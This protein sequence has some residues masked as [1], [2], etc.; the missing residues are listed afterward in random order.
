MTQ[1]HAH[2]FLKCCTC[3]DSDT[4]TH[5]PQML[6]DMT[7]IHTCIPMPYPHII[8]NTH[9]YIHTHKIHT[10]IK[11]CICLCVCL[12]NNIYSCNPHAHEQLVTLLS[13]FEHECEPM[14]H[15]ETRDPH[16]LS[17]LTDLHPPTIPNG[18]SNTQHKSTACR[19][20]LPYSWGWTES[21]MF[22]GIISA[23]DPVSVI[24][25]VK[26]LGVIP[27]FGVLMEGEAILN[28]GTSMI[29]Y[30]LCF[31]LLFEQTSPVLMFGRGVQLVIGALLLGGVFFAVSH[32]CLSRIKTP[33]EQ[34]IVTVSSAYLC[35]FVAEATEIG[36]SGV[37]A[38]FMQGFLMA[39]FGRS[40]FC[41]DSQ[42]TLQAFWG[43]L[44]YLSDTLVFILAGAIIVDKAFLS[45]HVGDYLTA[46]D[47]GWM[48]LLFFLTLL[49]R[50][51]VVGVCCVYLRR[52]GHCLDPS[53]CTFDNFCKKMCILVVG[54][55]RGTVALVLS[56]RCVVCFNG[57]LLVHHAYSCLSRVPFNS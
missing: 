3:H 12:N 40:L 11:P 19:Y 55:L 30:E 41:A 15:C 16:T 6:H 34:T 38:V 54:G 36:V 37:L 32:F 56:L 47:W 48:F 5:V 1:I 49:I 24:A 42:T 2:M 26:E 8:Y 25:L 46:Q 35:Y 20:I 43:M 57:F 29:I 13:S 22:G 17:I 51:I 23:T 10:Y 52:Y 21:L 53:T 33:Q 45:Q 27:D 31:T 50:A 44:I 28:D 9:T 14:Q 18:N 4:C 39:G 7:R